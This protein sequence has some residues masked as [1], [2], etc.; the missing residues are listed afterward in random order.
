MN[1]ASLLRPSIVAYTISLVVTAATPAQAAPQV[2]VQATNASRSASSG[3]ASS[4]F[5]GTQSEP[6]NPAPAAE[7]PAPTNAAAPSETTPPAPPAGASPSYFQFTEIQYLHG[8]YYR[9]P[10]SSNHQLQKEIITFQ[11]YG[12]WAFG[13]NFFFFDFIKSHASDG[14]ANEV[15]GEAYTTLSASKIFNTSLDASIFHDIGITMGINVGA[16]TN[17]SGPLIISPE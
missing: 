12:E 13:R 17:S 9:E 5:N 2:G 16:K 4:G 7:N 3:S 11:H 6:A 8:F 15:Y 14:D 10:G 1:L